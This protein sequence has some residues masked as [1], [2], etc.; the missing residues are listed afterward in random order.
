MPKDKKYPRIE[1]KSG[2]ILLELM[3]PDVFDTL[4]KHHP[5]CKLE[6]D[7][8][9]YLTHLRA[10]NTTD[11]AELAFKNACEAAREWMQIES[12]VPVLI[13]R[14]RNG[15]IFALPETRDAV[16][17]YRWLHSKAIKYAS[18]ITEHINRT[19]GV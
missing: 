19:F 1:L 11:D 7:S 12:G 16:T 3:E 5:E 6:S 13:L 18:R 14:T 2:T 10:P 17:K 8:A 4:Y 15:V 9:A